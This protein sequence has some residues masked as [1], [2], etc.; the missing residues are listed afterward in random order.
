MRVGIVAPPWIPVPPPAYG[1]T[2]AVIDAIA[3]G[4]A[5][6]GHEVWL[7]ATRDSTCQVNRVA[8]GTAPT[9]PIGD[10]GAERNHVARAYTGLMSAQVDVIHDHTLIGPVYGDRATSIPIVTTVHGP[11]DEAMLARYRNMPADVSIIA[12]SRHQASTARGV[13][14]DTVIHHG[15]DHRAISP[16]PGDGGYLAFLGRMTPS[17]GV[18][19]AIAVARA[20]GVPL[21]IAAKMR[22]PAER[23][24]FDSAV[25]PLLGQDCEYLGE[26]SR[27]DKYALLGAAMALLNPIQWD[28]PFGMV[29]IEAMAAGTPVIATPRGASPEIVEDGITGYLRPDI[30]GLAEAIPLVTALDRRIVRSRVEERFSRERL[31]LDHV[32]FFKTVIEG[33]PASAARAG[34]AD[35]GDF[36]SAV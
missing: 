29:M 9:R 5:E 32:A 21:K 26:L 2:E 33:S 30:R 10:L 15:V 3:V 13:R 12:I 35:Y 27:E 16:G 34:M 19:E 14:I 36:P 1:G 4:M 23:E 6:L 8:V 17:K 24:F 25:A 7:A 20:S 31:A 11:F 28:E 22:E 18:P